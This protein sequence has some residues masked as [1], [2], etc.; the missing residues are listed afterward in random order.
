MRGIA[1]VLV[2]AFLV[3]LAGSILTIVLTFLDDLREI[4]K[5]D[6][7]TVP[8]SNEERGLSPQTPQVSAS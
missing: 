4:F 1:N 7:P 8:T 6:S 3:G 2:L 5:P